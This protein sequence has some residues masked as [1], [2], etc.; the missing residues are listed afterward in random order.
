MSAYIVN[1]DHIDYLVS[2]VGRLGADLHRR[3]H[4]E[5]DP[6]LRGWETD[7]SPAAIRQ[8]AFGHIYWEPEFDVDRLGRLLLAENIRSVMARYPGVDDL[9][10]PVPTPEATTYRHTSVP[11]EQITPAGVIVAV[12][13]WRYQTCETRDHEQSLAW[14]V[15]DELYDMAV[16]AMI[17]SQDPDTW[18][19]TRPRP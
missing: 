1:V 9:P 5:H 19:W 17:S 16:Q 2:A 10:G 15:M 13:C 11:W 4:V 7:F 14:R 6:A 3:L 12:K 18:N 8:G